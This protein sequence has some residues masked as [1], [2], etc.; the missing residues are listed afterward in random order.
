MS[1]SSSKPVLVTEPNSIQCSGC[2]SFSVESGCA[3]GK[4]PSDCGH[5]PERKKSEVRGWS[6]RKARFGGSL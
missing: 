5:R 2:L 1:P 4:T 6:G 3:E